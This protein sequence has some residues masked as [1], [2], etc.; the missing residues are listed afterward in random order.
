MKVI[1]RGRCFPYIGEAIWGK[2]L[3]FPQEENVRFGGGRWR[4][5]CAALNSGILCAIKERKGRYLLISLLGLLR[6]Y[7]EL[8]RE[9]GPHWS[10]G[11][12]RQSTVY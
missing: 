3:D 11:H 6:L 1:G 5:L 4:V 9:C 10:R 7:A 8:E 12:F 2:K